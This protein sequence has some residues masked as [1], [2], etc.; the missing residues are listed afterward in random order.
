MFV[1]KTRIFLKAGN[2]GDGSISFLRD[3]TTM[4]GG[5]D[6]GNGGKGGDTGGLGFS[7][8]ADSQRKHQ[9]NKQY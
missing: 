6:G 1:D 3:R 8:C 5:P 4:T 9:H 2:G 7:T